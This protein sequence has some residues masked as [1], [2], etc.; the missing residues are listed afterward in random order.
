MEQAIMRPA[1]F[2]F[3]VLVTGLYPQDEDTFAKRRADMVRQQIEQRGVR[4]QA[5]LDALK[6]VPRHRFV[7][8]DQVEYAYED[9]PLPIGYGQT[10]SQPYIVAFMT[11]VVQPEDD[12]KVL[13]IG[14][15]SGYQAAVL[16]EIVQQVYSVEIVEELH[17][18]AST[19]FEDLGYSN[20]TSTSADGY[21]GW[22]EHAPYDAIIVTAA[23]E[24]IPPPLI[25]QLK[26][27]G[28]M[29]IPVGS[30]FRVQNLMLV[31]KKDGK[32]RTKTLF[33]VMFVPFTKGH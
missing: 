32:I 26:E 18:R 12:F 25:S 21:F 8:A 7:P 5:T 27:N 23:P 11:E 31:E 2:L 16:A 6:T 10:I 17:D 15:G 28:K 24:Y 33:P 14:T 22:E 4:D 13:E 1:L 19:L 9:R 3:S 30:P 20:I 29:I